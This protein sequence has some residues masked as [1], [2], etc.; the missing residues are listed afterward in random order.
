MKSALHAPATAVSDPGEGYAFDNVHAT[1]QHRCLAASL[2][3]ITI[4]RLAGTGVTDGW[5][6]LE[7][8]AG[9]GVATWLADPQFRA[10]SCVIYSVQGRR[11]R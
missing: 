9:G 8:G 5:R 7:V 10:G 3:P 4:A 2:D 11:A 6:C 1:E